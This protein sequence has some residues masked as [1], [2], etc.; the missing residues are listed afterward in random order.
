[1][2]FNSDRMLDLATR[3]N[4]PLDPDRALAIIDEFFNEVG[5]PPGQSPQLSDHV[6]MML[7]KKYKVLP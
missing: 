1:M 3:A 2:S 5:T 7:L 4:A 6:L